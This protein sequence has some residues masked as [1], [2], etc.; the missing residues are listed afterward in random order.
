MRA[1]GAS[2]R[3]DARVLVLTSAAMAAFAANSLLCRLALGRGD[4]DPASFTLVRLGAA[5]LTLCA[6]VAL[7]RTTG[8]LRG[9][10]RGAV[11]LFAYA[12]A[13]SWAYVAL[14]ASTGALLRVGA[15]QGTMVM[16]GRLRGERLARMQWTGFLVALGGLIVLLLPGA[17]AP[18]IPGALLMLAAGAAWGVYSLMGRDAVDPLPETAGNFLRAFPMAVAAFA[19]AA[20]TGAHQTLDG[21]FYAV[22]SGAVASG[23]GYTIWYAVLPA[24][25]SVQ[26]ASVQLSVPVLTALAGTLVLGEG[27]SFRL[28]V[29]SVATLGGIALVIRGRR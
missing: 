10:W 22:L 25:S 27:L 5:V 14:P 28:T 9:T 6:I 18:P 2:R 15:V 3:L 12:A 23:V 11:A 20:M 19:L 21:L 1:P 7:R 8:P 24:L 17:S 26:A 4:M 16:A 29:S 13:F